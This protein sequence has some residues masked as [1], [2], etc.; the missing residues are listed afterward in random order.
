M[1]VIDNVVHF[2]VHTSYFLML[3]TP[4]IS[5]TSFSN[6]FFQSLVGKVFT[7]FLPFF[8]EYHRVSVSRS[9]DV[10]PFGP[11]IPASSKF[12]KQKAFANFLLTKSKYKNK[13]QV[14]QCVH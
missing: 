9:K 3:I 4:Y 6:F 12:G 11:P 1:T 14:Y 7:F 8:S 10:P 2:C 5:F 13:Q